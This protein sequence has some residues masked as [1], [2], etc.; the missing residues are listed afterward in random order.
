MIR[1][2]VSTLKGNFLLHDLKIEN[3]RG[4]GLC[5]QRF[6]KD[7]QRKNEW[8]SAGESVYMHRLHVINLIIMVLFPPG[9]FSDFITQKYFISYHIEV[10]SILSSS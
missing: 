9:L 4:G 8:V 7:T 1:Q 3:E 5:G 10:L 6:K 2:R